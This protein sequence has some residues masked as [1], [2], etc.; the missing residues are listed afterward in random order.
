MISGAIFDAPHQEKVLR[1]WLPRR[2][3]T[4]SLQLTGIFRSETEALKISGFAHSKL[5]A[6]ALKYVVRVFHHT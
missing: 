2:P 1:N 4:N 5:Q 6:A 3:A